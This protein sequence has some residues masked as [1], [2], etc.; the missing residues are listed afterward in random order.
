MI[1][2]KDS[3]WNAAGNGVADDGDAIRAAIATGAPS[4]FLPHGKYR[5]T[6]PLVLG[7][8]QSLIGD[9]IADAV[10]NR[11]TMLFANEIES[12]PAI[13]FIG[14][15]ELSKFNRV[16]DFR[17]RGPGP[18]TT[19][20]TTGILLGASNIEYSVNNFGWNDVLVEWF[21]I[22]LDNHGADNCHMRGGGLYECGIGGRT[23]Q[24]SF[25]EVTSVDLS[26]HS[27]CGWDITTAGGGVRFATAVWSNNPCHLKLRSGAR[28]TMDSIWVEGTAGGTV[29]CVDAA[30]E[31]QSNAR[32]LVI[33]SHRM[34]AGGTIP[35]VVMAGGFLQFIACNGAPELSF[36][37]TAATQVLGQG[38]QGIKN[39]SPYTAGGYPVTP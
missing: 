25:N 31:S 29:A 33:A 23:S 14:D 24:N 8:N 3:P 27:I 32:L 18:G 36:D 1:N 28:A 11:G 7:S 10:G 5:F 17:L 15:G 4:I 39:G 13:Q 37:V 26:G 30:S 16:R 21:G 34:M 12:G 19:T 2:V 35:F 38:E 6:S 20:S 22:G 9:G